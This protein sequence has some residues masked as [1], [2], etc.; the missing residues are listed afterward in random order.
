MLV[1]VNR[2]KKKDNSAPKGY[3]E[4]YAFEDSSDDSQDQ[5]K[6][7]ILFVN[8]DVI[9]NCSSQVDLFILIV[10]I[11]NKLVQIL[12]HSVLYIFMKHCFNL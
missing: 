10:I 4:R 8:H 9:W 1:I 12:I 2:V 11:I 6:V 7:R 3:K 5:P